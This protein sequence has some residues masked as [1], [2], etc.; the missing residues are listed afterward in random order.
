MFEI[1]KF[2]PKDR[3]ALLQ[4]GADT[5]FFG[6]PIENYMDDRRIFMDAF[7]AYYTDYE[8]E[9]AWVVCNEDQLGGFLTGSVNPERHRNMTSRRIFPAVLWN[10]IC[11]KYKVG[12]KTWRYIHAV[13]GAWRRN[14]F[15]SVDEEM[16]PA[17]LHINLL[18]AWRRQGMGRRLIEVYLNQLIEAD[19]PGVHLQT[20]S[21]NIDACRLYEKVGFKLLDA[22]LTQMYNHLLAQ[23]VE[24]RCYGL[25][26]AK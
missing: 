17:H 9:Y 1:R 22:R 10:L 18:P 15:A 5:A 20:T 4:I 7:Y 21:L 25:R 13:F 6:A 16:Y 23:T 24:N 12:R 14:E 11:G 26:L 8:P 19:V 3:E 2:Q